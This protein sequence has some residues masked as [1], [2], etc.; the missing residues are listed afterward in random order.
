MQERGLYL[1]QHGMTEFR[2]LLEKMKALNVNGENDHLHPRTHFQT[3]DNGLPNTIVQNQDWF[4]RMIERK[5]R[6]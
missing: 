3:V 1:I 5:R 6:K 4:E 2:I